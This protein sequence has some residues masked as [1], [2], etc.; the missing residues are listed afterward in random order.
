MATVGIIVNPWAGKDVRRLHA[1]VGQ[2]S[3]AAKVGS[4]HRIAAGALDAGADR[5]AVLRDA[6][7]IA[8]RALARVAGGELIDGE[9][10]GS[11]LDTRRGATKLAA[12]GCL[13]IVVLG[14]DGT[15]RDVAIGAPHAVIIPISTGTNNV[16]PAFIDGSSAGTAAGL[17]ARGAL[18]PHAVGRTAKVLH[19]DVREADGTTSH[20]IALVDLALIDGSGVGA[21]AVVRASAVKLVV[22]V[23]ASAM[24]TGLSAIAGR[25]HPID[26]HVPGAVVVHTGP[27]GRTIGVPIVPGSHQ[28]IAVQSVDVLPEGGCLRF[29]GP[30]V[31]AFDGER[32]RVIREDDVVTVTVRTDGPLVIDVARALQCAVK[33]RLFDVPTVF[34]VPAGEA[35]DGD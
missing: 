17:L 13:P 22:A 19:V 5:V 1:P 15:C 6:G 24:S 23:I 12:M 7:R 27:H 30:G 32:E 20:D 11:A 3:D 8:E 31:L 10:T 35:H 16:F 28:D 9:G 29:A 14:G 34:D 18:D 4:V 33:R 25:L 26:R 2:T 21:R